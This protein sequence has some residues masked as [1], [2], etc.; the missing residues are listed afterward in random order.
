M[1]WWQRLVELVS[2]D[3]EAP[4]EFPEDSTAH[5]GEEPESLHHGRRRLKEEFTS[6]WDMD[7]LPREE[8]DRIMEENR[9]K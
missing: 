9:N 1:H 3:D 5:P 7:Y 4:P 8:L 2:F 6:H